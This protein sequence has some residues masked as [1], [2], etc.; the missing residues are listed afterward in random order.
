MIGSFDLVNLRLLLGR[1]LQQLLKSGLVFRI[2]HLRSKKFNILYH[3]LAYRSMLNFCGGCIT[4]RSGS[5]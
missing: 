5:D 1:V 3:Y 2:G 4:I